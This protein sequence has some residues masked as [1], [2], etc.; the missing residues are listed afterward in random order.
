[1]RQ[2]LAVVFLLLIAPLMS[3]NIW[4]QGSPTPNVDIECPDVMEIADS[5]VVGAGSN[6]TCT[7]TNPTNYMEDVS[8]SIQS[9]G[10]MTPGLNYSVPG[11]IVIPPL[12]QVD[13][14]V[15]F[16]GT[17]RAAHVSSLWN[18]SAVVTQANGVANPSPVTKTVSVEVKQGYYLENGC[19]TQAASNESHIR[20]EI[21]FY[22]STGN[23]IAVELNYT[24]APIISENFALLAEMGC[25][26]GVLFHRVIDNFIQGGDFTNGGGIVGGHA[27]KWHGYCAGI[28]HNNSSGTCDPVLWTLPDNSSNQLAHMPFA[29]A[30]APYYPSSG[31]GSQFMIMDNGFNYSDSLPSSNIGFVFGKVIAGQNTVSLIS[32]SSVLNSSSGELS[33]PLSPIIITSAYPFDLD[34]DGDGV[35]DDE[36]AFPNDANESADTDG[37]GVGNNADAFP[38]DANESADTDGDGVGNNADAFPE[39][40]NESVDSDGDGVGD[41]ADVKPEDPDISVEDDIQIEE[42]RILSDTL[43]MGLIGASVFLGLCFLFMGVLMRRKKAPDSPFDV[44]ESIW[45]DN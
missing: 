5:L 18:I 6:L 27:A 25:F 14:E 21:E 39:D 31:G 45:D 28:L 20:M 38:E 42:Q 23:I 35:I 2:S 36:D 7:L 8:V 4:A 3:V 19:T 40:A 33:T 10:S 32:H 1:M 22:N 34:S 30:M 17:T 16:N 29:L 15:V 13:F 24:A 44:T 43:L 41:N 37:D 12:G 9:I 26:D 11:D